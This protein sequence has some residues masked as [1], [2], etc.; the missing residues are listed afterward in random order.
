MTKE[1]FN[2]AIDE[3]FGFLIGV[4]K[5]QMDQMKSN[6][7]TVHETNVDTIDTDA[8]AQ[9]ILDTPIDLRPALGRIII[10]AQPTIYL[11]DEMV[12]T[13]ENNITIGEV[14]DLKTLSYVKVG[15]DTTF[16]KEFYHHCPEVQDNLVRLHSDNQKSVHVCPVCGQKYEQK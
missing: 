16:G 14:G 1:K 15:T 8:V 11:G 6:I 13:A 7:K 12:C 4:Q 3:I 10:P 9:R 5:L 2:Q